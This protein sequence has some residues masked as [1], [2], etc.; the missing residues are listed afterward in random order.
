MEPGSDE[1]IANAAAL[2]A[3]LFAPV[4]FNGLFTESVKATLF[5]CPYFT[6]MKLLFLSISSTV[7]VVK[8][9]FLVWPH[10]KM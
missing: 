8:L 3:D 2:M 5:L 10:L 9:P 1:F 4:T 6:N 7:K